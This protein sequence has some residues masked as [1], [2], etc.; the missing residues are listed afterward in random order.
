MGFRRLHTIPIHSHAHL[1]TPYLSGNWQFTSDARV[2]MH[3]FK[4]DSI[5]TSAVYPESYMFWAMG[6]DNIF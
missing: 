5:V 3:G 2:S 4:T 6:A 1:A